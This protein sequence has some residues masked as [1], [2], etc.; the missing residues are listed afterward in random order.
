MLVVRSL[1]DLRKRRLHGVHVLEWW[2]PQVKA[3]AAGTILGHAHEASAM[4][5]VVAAVVAASDGGRLAEVSVVVHVVTSFVFHEAP[6]KL[7]VAS[8]QRKQR[9][10]GDC[11]GMVLQF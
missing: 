6:Q 9:S 8:C 4:A 5:E 10:V 7:P 2:Q 11:P 1:D 3:L